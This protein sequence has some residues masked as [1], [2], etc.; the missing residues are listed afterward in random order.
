[1]ETLL[2]IILL[3]L[4]L[5]RA[6][7][8]LVSYQNEAAL[9]AGG[10]KEHGKINSI[11]LAVFHILIYIFCFIEGLSKGIVF[12]VVS[13]FGILIY[14]FSIVV[15]F[16]TMAQ[17]NALWTIKI[18][19]DENYRNKSSFFYPYLH[20]TN[21]FTNVIPELI[22]LTMIFEAWNTAMFLLPPYIITLIYRVYI[23]GK[24]RKGL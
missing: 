20:H 10:A 1:M 2:Y 14:C 13:M 19:L 15:I 24:L 8:L 6:F 21:Y 11:I 22:G 12:D 23:K 9:K 3:L 4:G 18:L 7:T 5:G 16:I 17:L